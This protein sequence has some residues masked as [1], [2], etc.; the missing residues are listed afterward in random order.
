MHIFSRHRY[1]EL[2]E[3]IQ[4][5]SKHPST[6]VGVLSI[7]TCW[8]LVHLQLVGVLLDG[9][10]FH[11]QGNAQWQLLDGNARSGGLVLAEVFGVNG[12]KLSELSRHVSQEDVGLNN[13]LERRV[14]GIQDV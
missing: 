8:S 4:N 6:R 1:Q 10:N 7:Y 11:F 9:N 13:V 2:H 14:G 12:V 3:F 5:Y